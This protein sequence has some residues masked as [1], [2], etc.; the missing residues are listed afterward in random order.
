MIT[1]SCQLVEYGWIDVTLATLDNEIKIIASYLLDAP[2]DL[3]IALALLLEG[4][5]ETVC[6]WQDE[7]G[8]YR[9]VFTKQ[10]NYFE[11]KILQLEET[12]SH[13]SNENANLIFCGT[14]NLVKFSHKILREFDAI[15]IQHTVDGYKKLWGHE[16]PSKAIKRLRCALK[17]IKN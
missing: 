16:Y 4:L 8:E 12:F 5:N 3:I 15:K 13:K 14:D 2:N 10:E 9:W 7:P 17:E 1:F 11:L 6:L